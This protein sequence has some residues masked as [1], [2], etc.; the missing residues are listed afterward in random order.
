MLRQRY[1]EFSMFGS[2]SSGAQLTSRN[3][4][5][6]ARDSKMLSSK[7]TTTSLDLI[8]TK[9][10]V[11]RKLGWHQFLRALEECA[12]VRGCSVEDIHSMIIASRPTLNSSPPDKVRFH[13]DK[14]FYTG[15][16]ARGG[17]T[18][19]ADNVR[20]LEQLTDRSDADVRGV[21]KILYGGSEAG[22]SA[23]KTKPK[24]SREQYRQILVS[25]LRRHNPSKL[26]NVDILLTQYSGR[27]NDLFDK[28][29]IKYGESVVF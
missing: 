8:F 14:S 25:Y 1:D 6:M 20:G 17:P 16:H 7:L 21:K 28:L 22:M 10:A 24:K 19:S 5:K 15:V 23:I 26:R 13:D 11:E 12:V 9:F 3:F 29:A 18:T 27:E 2:G 4:A